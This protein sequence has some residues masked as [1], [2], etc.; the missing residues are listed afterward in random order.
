MKDSM[1]ALIHYVRYALRQLRKSPGF[2]A[3]AVITLALGIGATTA[4]YTVLYAT[5]IEPMPYPHPEQLVMVWSKW[6]TGRNFVSVGDFLDW[7][8]QNTAFQDLNAWTGGSFNL[9]TADHP[10]TIAGQQTTP[11]WYSLQ[12]FQFYLGRDFVADEGVPGR[13]HEVILAHSLWER[14]GSDQNIIGHPIRINSEAYTVVG[15]LAP[16]VGDRLTVQLAVPL[17][18]KPEEIDHSYHRLLVMGRLKPG[19][20]MAQAQADMDVVAKRIAQDYPDSNK[21]WGVTVEALR[22]DFLPREIL[23]TYWLLMGAVGFVLLIACVNVANLLLARG[24]AR[25]KEVAVRASLGASRGEL[26]SQFL[27]ESAVLASLGGV[28]GIGFAWALVRGVMAIIPDNIVT[29][30]S[31]IGIS[32]PILLFTLLTTLVA[33]IGFGCAPAWQAAGADPNDALKEGG[34]AGTGAGTHSL[35]RALVVTEFALALTLLASAGLA[36]HSFFNLTQVDLGVRRDHILSFVLPVPTQRFS[37]PEQM[38]AFYHSLLEKLEA[39]PGVSRAEAATAV[40]VRGSW[41]GMAF[42]IVGKPPIEHSARPNADFQMVTPGYFDT[43]GIRVIRGRSFT[44]QDTASSIHVAMVN[45]DFVKRYLPDVDP[46][47]QEIVVEQ[48]VPGVTRLGPPVT[49]QIVGVFHNVRTGDMREDYPE[50]DV[51]FWQSP[52]PRAAMAVRTSGDPAAMTSSIAAAIRAADSD[53]PLAEIQTMDQIVADARSHDRFATVLYGGFAAMALLLAAV[54]IY[55]VMAFAVTQRTHEL[56]L[57]MALGA[58]REQVFGLILKEGATLASAG[59]LLGLLGACLVG[60]TMRGLLFGVGTIDVTAFASV[61]IVL[62]ASAVL[63]CYVPAR[64][65]A[66]VDPMVALRYE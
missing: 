60:R 41:F 33:A 62:L 37:Q 32:W 17:A 65:A 12:G 2:T 40:P 53:L 49:W 47:T 5:F 45:E 51:P 25:Q 56:G 28:I 36:I 30:E 13:D 20:T 64:R 55:G 52:W 59:L 50:I 44:D 14:M 16:G 3:V 15:V 42:T 46:V 57:R 18:F 7:K 29:S 1:N 66:R 9:S 19:V 23:K 31:H 61:A 11:G 38:V 4:I 43:F 6:T 24:T 10:E 63:A 26:F 34:R 22:N 48:L 8:R 54:G 58:G 27:V 21:T 39:I 35:R